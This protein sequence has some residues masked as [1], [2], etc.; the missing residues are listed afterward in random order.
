MPLTP[1]SQAPQ[2]EG[3]MVLRHDFFRV[4]YRQIL[5]TD[6]LHIGWCNMS[7]GKLGP[8]ANL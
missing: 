5:V 8:L 2:G 3:L 1:L 4:F 7:H 6:K